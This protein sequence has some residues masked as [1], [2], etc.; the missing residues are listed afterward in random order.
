MKRFVQINLRKIVMH[1][2]RR[3]FPLT[4]VLERVMKEINKR[5]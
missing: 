3:I 5:V 4:N 1:C 2:G